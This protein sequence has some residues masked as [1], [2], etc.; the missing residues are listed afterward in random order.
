MKN[1]LNKTDDEKHMHDGHRDRLFEL[2]F[3][4]GL[5]GLSDVQLLEL[6]LCYVFPRGDVNPLAHRLLNK[7]DDV[8][9]AL[10]A[11]V[12]QVRIVRGMGD[13]SSKKLSLL[14]A[15]FEEYTYRK[16]QNRRVV[17]SSM[18]FLDYLEQL[19]RFRK[20]EELHMFGINGLGEIYKS[21]VFGKGTNN[22]VTFELTD[23]MN[24]V[25]IN[26]ITG[27]VLAHNHPNDD[28]VASTTDE[29]SYDELK[30]MLETAGCYLVDSYVVGKNGIYSM[31]NK[32]LARIFDAT[33]DFLSLNMQNSKQ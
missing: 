3:K 16:M 30:R 21:Q 26:N 25:R 13:M 22:K 24:Y 11:P 6:I 9:T 31:K 4:S 19:L 5:D 2:A 1:Y 28:C 14:L 32:G 20:K 12:D 18:E 8:P 7:F 29:K 27:I 33:L 15:I 23:V 17:A 10:E